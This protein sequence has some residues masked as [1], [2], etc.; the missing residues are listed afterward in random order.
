MVLKA[1]VNRGSVQRVKSRAIKK[2]DEPESPAPVDET[3]LSID[4]TLL[5][6]LLMIDQFWLAS[7]WR[8]RD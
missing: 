8:G 3:S 7:C 5:F 2:V 4:V 6:P 1:A